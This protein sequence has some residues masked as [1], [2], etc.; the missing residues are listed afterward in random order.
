MRTA[1]S[2]G[3]LLLVLDVEQRDDVLAADEELLLGRL[4]AHLAPLAGGAQR[5][6]LVEHLLRPEQA[7][8]VVA[9][10]V[11]C[12]RGACVKLAGRTELIEL[13]PLL[14]VDKSSVCECVRASV[15][16]CVCLYVL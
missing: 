9:Q 1:S 7:R 14:R 13:G 8:R 6:A 15:Y 2:G 10:V 3:L 11:P 4:A 12:E 16:V 5:V